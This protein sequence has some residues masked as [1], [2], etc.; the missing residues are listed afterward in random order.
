MK[1]IG[2]VLLFWAWL[3]CSP[4]TAQALRQ[5][6]AGAP[7]THCLT[8]CGLWA[9]GLTPLECASL[10]RYEALVLAAFAAH[11]T[12]WHPAPVCRA[13]NGWEVRVYR[14]PLTPTGGWW[15]PG[16]PYAVA[17]V[18]LIPEQ[19]VEVATTSWPDSALAHELAHVTDLAFSGTTIF[20]PDH[21]AWCA[22][23]VARALETVSHLREPCP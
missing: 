16:I 4:V 8:T 20:G 2:Q 11:V 13:F 17:G 10:R 3:G 19:A 23:G 5:P 14:G 9:T 1:T 15:R 18:T 7:L 22:P 12:R 21:S 6:P